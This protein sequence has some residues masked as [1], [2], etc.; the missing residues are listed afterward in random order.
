MRQP[1]AGT[2]RAGRAARAPRV[3][4]PVTGAGAA[5]VAACLRGGEGG[6]AAVGQLQ[7][8]A[9]LTVG[10]VRLRW[11]PSSRD[12]GETTPRWRSD[13]DPTTTRTTFAQGDAPT[14]RQYGSRGRAVGDAMAPQA[15]HYPLV[16][17]HARTRIPRPTPR[18]HETDAGWREGSAR[19]EQNLAG[20]LAGIGSA[21]WVFSSKDRTR[22]RTKPRTARIPAGAGGTPWQLAYLWP[23]FHQWLLACTAELTPEKLQLS[24]QMTPRGAF[25]RTGR[26][27]R[28]RGTRWRDSA[29]QSWPTQM[30]SLRPAGASG[31]WRAGEVR[32]RATSCSYGTGLAGRKG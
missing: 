5:T 21:T 19:P 3:G 25:V 9:V 17:L 32:G 26:C 22:D 8:P 4:C 13:G 10:W 28:R 24:R 27:R 12:L 31:Y 30:M 16:G 6:H 2:R 29:D 18:S 20:T 14:E 7:L 1:A 15:G 23:S 11:L